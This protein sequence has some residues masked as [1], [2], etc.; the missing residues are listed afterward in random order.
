MWILLSSI[1]TLVAQAQQFKTIELDW[2]PIAKASHYEVRLS[3]VNGD[4][5]LVFRS[6]EPRL[7]QEI[8]V[9]EYNLSVR[10]K[11][12]GYEYY[13]P[14]SKAVKVAVELKDLALVA[15]EDKATIDS[16]DRVHTVTFKWTAVQDAKSYTL[17]IWTLSNPQ[18]I[19]RFRTKGISKNLSLK[20]GEEYQWK[21][22]FDSPTVSYEQHP[23]IFNLTVLGRKVTTPQITRMNIDGEAPQI[24]WKKIQGVSGY[25][26][27]VLHRYF[28]EDEFK[29][30]IENSTEKSELSL[31]LPAPKGIYRVELVA[32]APLRAPSEPAAREETIK[33][34]ASDVANAL[35]QLDL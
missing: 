27:K 6:E 28:D 9:G 13:S 3:P 23:P 21:V 25:Q 31:P 10:A 19:K 30:V 8:P 24:K 7:V 4:S 20:T 35:D 2:D 5:P 1:F 16:K 34:S 26:V 12:K 11:A 18:D 14:W 17:A 15:P 32:R 29:T 22:E 33:P